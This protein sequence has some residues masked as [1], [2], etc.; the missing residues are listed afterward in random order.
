M[1]MFLVKLAVAVTPLIVLVASVNIITSIS[2]WSAQ[3]GPRR[4]HA[5][6]LQRRETFLA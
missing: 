3:R 6:R 5:G 1:E 4:G 2:K